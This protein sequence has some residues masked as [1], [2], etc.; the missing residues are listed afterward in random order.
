[1]GFSRNARLFFRG[2]SDAMQDHGGD[3]VAGSR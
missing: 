1:V 2:T 3:A